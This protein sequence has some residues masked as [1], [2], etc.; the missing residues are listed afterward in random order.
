MPRS[1][2]LGAT[3]ARRAFSQMVSKCMATEPVTCGNYV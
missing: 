3:V 1:S 2:L